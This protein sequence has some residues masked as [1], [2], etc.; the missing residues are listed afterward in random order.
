MNI[1][2]AYERPCIASTAI[3]AAIQTIFSTRRTRTTLLYYF[4]GSI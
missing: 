4:S 2:K 3:T 1:V